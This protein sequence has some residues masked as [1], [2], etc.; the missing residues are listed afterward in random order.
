[1]SPANSGTVSWGTMPLFISSAKPEMEVSG[2]FSS[3]ETLALNS[4]RR[5]SRF[6]RSVTS[7]MASTAPASR[8]SRI[9]GLAKS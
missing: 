7:R 1:M 4:R 3:W 2:V 9:T 8:P 6:S 5:A